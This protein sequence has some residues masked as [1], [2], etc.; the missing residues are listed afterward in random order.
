MDTHAEPL[1]RSAKMRLRKAASGK[2][3][4][5]TFLDRELVAIIDELKL[6]LGARSRGEVLA[7]ILREG[8]DIQELREEYRQL[9]RL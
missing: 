3:N 5:N 8:L 9:T 7:R 1:D 6:V 4:F 2:V